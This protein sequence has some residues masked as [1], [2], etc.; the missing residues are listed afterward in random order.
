[1][2]RAAPRRVGPRR[3]LPGVGC[4]LLLWACGTVDWSSA[5][6]TF[7]KVNAKDLASNPQQFWARGVIFEDIL[8]E[9]PSGSTMRLDGQTYTRVRLEV[10]GECYASD[11]AAQALRDLPLH[12]P[13]LFSGTVV[14]RGGGGFGPGWLRGGRKFVRVLREIS[15]PADAMTEAIQDR[16]DLEAQLLAAGTNVPP[17]LLPM[18]NII[19]SIEQGLFTFASENGVEVSSLFDPNSEFAEM[20]DRL[21]LQEIRR[22]ERTEGLSV[23]Q[24]LATYTVS[25]LRRRYG[26]GPTAE[27]TP[28]PPVGTPPEEVL[29][30]EAPQDSD[31]SEWLAPAVPE[32][33]PQT[34]GPVA[35][36]LPTWVEAVAEPAAPEVPPATVTIEPALESVPEPVPEEPIVLEARWELPVAEEPPAVVVEG[37]PVEVPIVVNPDLEEFPG[38]H[39]APSPTSVETP[40]AAE[41]DVPEIVD[42]AVPQPAEQPAQPVVEEAEMPEPVMTEEVAEDLPPFQI[43][44]SE[45][46][47]EEAPALEQESPMATVGPF[48]FPLL[49]SLLVLDTVPSGS[50]E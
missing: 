38:L 13:Y 35:E 19:R 44:G 16:E 2:K 47:V 14:Q 21:A 43:P 17:E 20:P 37:E 42:A 41:P 4:A 31:W 29:A 11:A 50:A 6:D 10:V 3:V 5:Q 24:F 15:V 40:A 45:A 22:L 26:V 27:V 8:V 28:G 33:P 39:E 32:P 7:Q 23:Q 12:R 18:V 34:V 46:P 36:D 30:P 1:M 9:H 49:R 48:R 25:L